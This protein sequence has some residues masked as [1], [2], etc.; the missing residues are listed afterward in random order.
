[1]SVFFFSVWVLG[2]AAEIAVEGSFIYEPREASGDFFPFLLL[3][4]KL[5]AGLR[6]DAS[7]SLLNG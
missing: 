1:M 5:P 6:V 2:I 7:M 3:T 4:T